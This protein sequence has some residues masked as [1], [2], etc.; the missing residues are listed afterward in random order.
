MWFFGA[1]R[2]NLLVSKLRKHSSFLGPNILFDPFTSK[3]QQLMF[4]P[5]VI[6]ALRTK[7][8]AK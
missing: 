1:E 6:M 3:F 5:K 4:F 7:Q 2:C 8:L